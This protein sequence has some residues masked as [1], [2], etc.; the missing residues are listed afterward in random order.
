M[1]QFFVDLG[2]DINW[3]MVSVFV[4]TV[5]I[6]H[7]AVSITE[8]RNKRDREAAFAKFRDDLIEIFDKRYV[9]KADS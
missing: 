4:G 9:R 8:Q 5:V 7:F 1:I 3:A 6:Y 2:G